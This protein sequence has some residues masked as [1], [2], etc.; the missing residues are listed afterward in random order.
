MARSIRAA[1]GRPGM[2][3]QV[4]SGCGLF[5][6]LLGAE[7]L[8]CT[9]IPVSDGPTKRQVQLIADFEP[10]LIMVT[11]SRMLAILDAFRSAGL[12]PRATTLKAGIFGAESG[13]EAMRAEIESSFNMHA[14]DMYSLSEV[15]GPG[16]AQ[17]C[18]E[19][20][21]GLHIWEDYV[22]PE[23][24]DP[25]TGA[26]LPDGALGE[27]VFTTLAQAAMPIIRYRTRD[28][29]CL[30]PGTARSMRRMARLS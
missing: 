24:I 1:G 25:E 6:G 5:S 18:V 14:L 8:G 11:P 20:K 19:T 27:L 21:D 30:L 23:V 12:D 2:R 7:K 13:T 26:V 22:Y 9:V 10:D 3:V 4:A 16:I 17:E 29:T 15:M 28:R